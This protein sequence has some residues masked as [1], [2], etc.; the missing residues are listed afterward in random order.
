M[1]M[2]TVAENVRDVAAAFAQ[3]RGE[4]QRRRALDPADFDHL[5]DTGLLLA[6]APS[7][8]GGLWEGMPRS[9]RALAD[10]F[11][12]LAKGD[13]SVALVASMHPAVLSAYGWLADAQAPPP[14]ADAWAEQKR[15]IFQTVTDGAWWSTIASEPG[16]GGD[17]SKTKSVARC[18]QGDGE[19]RLSGLKHFGSGTGV[20]SYMITV[21]IPEGESRRDDFI[22]DM[23]GIPFDGSA[24]VKLVAPWDGHGM[25]A[26]QSHMLMFEDF[27]A[28]RAAAPQ[29][30]R[31]SQEPSGG[32]PLWPAIMAGIVATAMET[33]REALGRRPDWRSFERVEWTRAETEAWLVEQAYEGMLRAVEQGGAGRRLAKI[34]IA[35]LAESV[36]QRLCRIVGGGTYGRESPFGFWFEDVRALGFLRPPWGL[37]FDNL[38]A[39]T[40][41]NSAQRPGNA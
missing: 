39:A 36:L 27:P 11:R 23:R 17:T 18:G 35:E 30:V 31:R 13:S 12:M 5:R 16:S 34:A 6:C 24:G 3:Q 8:Y 19:Y 10:M 25:A 9:I 21:A 2:Q 41:E 26:T 1:D 28:R 37:A 29:A 14:Y 33:A 38:F 40:W 7:R 4:R 32:S 20:A 15:W 22:L